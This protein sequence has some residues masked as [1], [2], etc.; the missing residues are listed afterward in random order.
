MARLPVRPA[1]ILASGAAAAAA[2]LGVISRGRGL[3]A[4]EEV[5]GGQCCA[6]CVLEDLGVL[7]CREGEQQLEGREGDTVLPHLVCFVYSVTRPDG[8]AERA[9][10]GT[11]GQEGGRGLGRVAELVRNRKRALIRLELSHTRHTS[12][13]SGRVGTGRGPCMSSRP[14]LPNTAPL[15]LLSWN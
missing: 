14:G 2:K 3:A 5:V 1:G 15:W 8:R 9:R 6:G 13:S 4:V 11:K 10:G 7:C 12:G